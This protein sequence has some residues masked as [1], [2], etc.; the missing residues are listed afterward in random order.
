M[1]SDL[2]TSSGGISFDSNDKLIFGANDSNVELSTGNSPL[3]L[4][5]DWIAFDGAASG[6]GS[7][8]TTFST[9][10]IL[11]IEPYNADFNDNFLGGSD[12][13]TGNELN[14]AGSIS[15][16]SS[17]VFRFTGDDAN[18]FRHLQSMII[19]DWEALS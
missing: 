4:K 7:G 19:H 5:S 11:K 12:G 6:S 17:G 9:T 16:V 18:D 14:W 15:E 3:T 8:Q 1:A 10:G 13:V 2:T